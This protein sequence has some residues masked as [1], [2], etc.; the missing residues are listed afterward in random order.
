MPTKPA[1]ALKAWATDANFSTGPKAG[2]PTKQEI[3]DGVAAEGHRPGKTAPT[4]AEY[5]NWWLWVLWYWIDWLRQGSSAGEATAH[6]CETNADGKLQLEALL[7]A[8][9]NAMSTAGRIVGPPLAGNALQLTSANTLGDPTLY[10]EATD[11]GAAIYAV[12]E[13]IAVECSSANAFGQATISTTATGAG[14]ALRSQ[15]SATGDYGATFQSAKSTGY[16]LWAIGSAS[17]DGAAL[18]TGGT[19]GNGFLGYSGSAAGTA[20][21]KGVSLAPGGFGVWAESDD[22]GN[23]SGGGIRARGLNAAPGGYFTAEDGAAI[24]L[25]ST[26]G[27]RAP[28]YMAPYAGDP[29]SKNKGSIC[30]NSNDALYK[31]VMSGNWCGIM[32]RRYGSAGEVVAGSNSS[33]TND[34]SN[35]VIIATRALADHQAPKVAGKVKIELVAGIG[36][37]GACSIGFDIVDVDAAV[38]IKSFDLPLYQSGGGVYERETKLACIYTVPAAGDRTFRVEMYR[39]GGAGT[40]TVRCRDVVLTVDGVYE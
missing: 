25:N 3:P 16:A 35:P 31:L 10:A 23:G 5:W 36:R 28:L 14:P 34:S 30:V 29:T 18:A 2:S 20:G 40:D 1:T 19:N 6:V 27:V 22:A 13:G 24:E 8:P 15:G 38:I 9:A 12:A 37:T 33:T 7:V 11:A 4:A 32:W 39:I 17:A 26:G 21:V